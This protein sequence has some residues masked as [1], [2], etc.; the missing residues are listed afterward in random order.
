MISVIIP[1]LNRVS[2]VIKLVQSIQTQK[3]KVAFEINVVSNLDNPQLRVKLDKLKIENLRFFTVGQIGANRARNLGA[4][5]STGNILAFFDD[6]CLLSTE[7]H[8]E[9][10]YTHHRNFNEASAIG[11]R[12]RVNRVGNIWEQTYHYNADEWLI[13][14]R[15]SEY[16][17]TNLIGGNVSYKREAFIKYRGFDNSLVYGGTE[18]ELH[19]R[20][21]NAGEQLI[22]LDDIPV[23]HDLELDWKG[24][25]DKALKQ[26]AA[27]QFRSKKNVQLADDL[28]ERVFEWQK[29]LRLSPKPDQL[30]TSSQIYSGVF[31]LG[32]LA[33]VLDP[34]R[35]FH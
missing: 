9:K 15:F 12:Y 20:M 16:L 3:T 26:G 18:T 27:F 25:V 7:D 23:I 6:D 2:S 28:K 35:F 21:L 4:K 10:I 34:K 8:L 29:S 11:G 19:L 14:S 22:L 17:A 13:A 33:A 30:L 1:T 31:S 24:F 5:N 32:R